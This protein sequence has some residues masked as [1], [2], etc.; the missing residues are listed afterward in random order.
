MMGDSLTQHGCPLP[1]CFG[2]LDGVHIP[3]ISKNIVWVAPLIPDLPTTSLT[4]L[5]EIK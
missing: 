5:F 4:N 1:N 2:F 3:G